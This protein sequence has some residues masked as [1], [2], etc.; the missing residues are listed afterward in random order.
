MPVEISQ[1]KIDYLDRSFHVDDNNL[2]TGWNTSQT[3]EIL[4]EKIVKCH[5]LNL[6]I[7]WQGGSLFGRIKSNR[8]NCLTNIVLATRFLLIVDPSKVNDV[9]LSTFIVSNYIFLSMTLR[10]QWMNFGTTW[11]SVYP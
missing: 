10:P 11:R 9:A 3:Q 6:V 4:R 5:T 8:Q 1:S 2:F 7:S